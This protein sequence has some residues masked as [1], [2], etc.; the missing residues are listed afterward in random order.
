MTCV[1]GL[2][3][4]KAVI[5]GADS[6]GVAGLSLTVRADPKVFCNGPMLIGYTSSFRMGQLL[7]FRLE[8]PP[9]HPPEKDDFLYMATDFIDAVRQCFKDHGYT[10]IDNSREEGGTFLVGYR[11]RIYEIAAD[12]QVGI[13]V[14]GFAAVGCGFEI[15]LGALYTT[16]GQ[17]PEERIRLALA[18]AQR[19]SAGVREPFVVERSE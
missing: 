3:A 9:H 11:G 1:V 15:A 10:K 17:N 4:D 13:P 7:R 19:F 2:I 8:I 5:M 18:A 16:D 12:Y 6:A 14:D